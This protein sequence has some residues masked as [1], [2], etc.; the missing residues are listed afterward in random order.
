MRYIVYGAGA[1]GGVIGGRLFQHGHDITFIA[2][3]HH[4]RVLR[5]SG[6]TLVDPEGSVELA[7]PT[8]EHPAEVE[9]RPDDV[10][11]LAMKTQ[12]TQ[13]AL[14]DLIAVAP[15]GLA[16]ACAQNGVENERLGLRHTG[17]TYGI[18]VMM[19]ASHLEP[20]VVIASS[21]PVAGILDIGRYPAGTDAVAER[22]ATDVSAA[23]FAARADAAI[24]RSKYAKLLMNLGNALEAACGPAARGSGLYGLARAEGE[25]CLAAAG[26]DV[27][28]QEDDRARRGDLL[29]V[30]PIN[31]EQRGGGSSWQSLARQ[32]GAVEADYLNGEVVLLG[33][34]H[35]VPT[36]VN[37]L[38]LRTANRMARERAEPGS[39]PIES[40]LAELGTGAER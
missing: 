34:Q 39:M 31:G 8:V 38:L 5:D 26:I 21:S 23:G 18:C 25:A 12:D 11:V 36:P 20:G 22:F 28:S 10:V 15:C 27:A 17:N 32:T 9:L 30:K 4:G 2:R 13:G 19:P 6:L 3:G 24:M 40:L 33:R 37:E 29:Q 14:R 35:G 16:V 1:I 7:V